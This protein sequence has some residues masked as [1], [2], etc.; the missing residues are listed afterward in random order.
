MP[1][2]QVDLIPIKLRQYH[3]FQCDLSIDCNVDQSKRNRS[4]NIMIGHN[5]GIC[6]RAQNW[7]NMLG[8]KN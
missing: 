3:N 1:L 4:G 7:G 5:I 8:L 6:A 2:V